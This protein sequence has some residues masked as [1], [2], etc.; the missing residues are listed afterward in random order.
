MLRNSAQSL[1]AA[2]TKVDG[3]FVD[4]GLTKL[5]EALEQLKDEFKQEAS[6]ISIEQTIG[7]LSEAKFE[8]LNAR[9]SLE[10]LANDTIGSADDVINKVKQ[11]PTTQGNSK[12]KYLFDKTIEYMI[13]LLDNSEIM[14]AE[15]LADYEEASHAL[16]DI[17][18][19]INTYKSEVDSFIDNEGGKLEKWIAEYR[20]GTYP[21]MLF[22][23][24]G[25]PFSVLVC[26]IVVAF[27]A[28]GVE[29][30]VAEAKRLFQVQKDN[31]VKANEI[32]TDVLN[33]VQKGNQYIVDENILIKN[34]RLKMSRAKIEVK[35][36]DAI[37]AAIEAGMEKDVEI[38]LNRLQEACKKYLE[39][40]MERALARKQRQERIKR[41]KFNNFR[42]NVE[43]L[44]TK[45]A[46]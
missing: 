27:T 5:D 39:H 13:T 21:Y 23:V 2:I 25:G 24:L 28:L 15:S 29:A 17:Q 8:I 40:E 19:N 44:Q 31:A 41:I 36:V 35:S 14:L 43:P 10:L 9:K 32:V 20:I 16:N 3:E 12:L 4:P 18:T 34:W 46:F 42:F 45:Y 33:E 37:I 30:N 26:P 1:E 22:C 38:A 6:R 11:F 7:N